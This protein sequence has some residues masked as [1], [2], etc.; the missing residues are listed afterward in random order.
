MADWLGEH[1]RDVLNI[2]G[3]TVTFGGFVLALRQ[4][5]ELRTEAQIARDATARTLDRLALNH[6]L[7]VLVELQHMEQELDQAIRA[8]DTVESSR[9]LVRWRQEANRLGGMMGDAVAEVD[10]ERI[11]QKLDASVLIAS[12]ARELIAS[13]DKTLGQATRKAVEAVTDAS[14]EISQL[15]AKLMM[16][17]GKQ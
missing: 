4:L 16:E 8:D 15:L 7:V 14:N 6:L 5:S 1:W 12:R 17:V 13:K 2:L 9:I 10:R 11:R 3:F